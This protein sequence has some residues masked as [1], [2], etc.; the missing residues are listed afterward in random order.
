MTHTVMHAVTVR[1][2]CCLSAVDARPTAAAVNSPRAHASRTCSASRA[3]QSFGEL[4]I[5]L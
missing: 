5:K 3:S 1:G 4:N 2:A